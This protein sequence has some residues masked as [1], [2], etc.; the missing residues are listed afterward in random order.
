MNVKR[1]P[2]GSG[3]S[4]ICERCGHE[5]TSSSSSVLC[6]VC[7]TVI[8]K[9]TRA[10][11]SG[12][13]VQSAQNY[14]GE[15]PVPPPGDSPTSQ[16]TSQSHTQFSSHESGYTARSFHAINTVNAPATAGFASAR[17]CDSALAVEFI[18]S[19]LGIFGIGWLLARETLIG[20]LVLACSI[21]N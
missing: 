2:R 1:I 7:G 11:S 14:A 12:N 9:H 4:M 5:I 15:R 18:L 13:Y 6:P 3:V 21:L 17:S 19:L 16:T 8:R 20:F 10:Q